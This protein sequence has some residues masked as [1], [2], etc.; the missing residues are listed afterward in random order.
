MRRWLPWLVA[1]LG[2]LPLLAVSGMYWALS[3]PGGDPVA[4]P[5]SAIALDSPEGA[6][7]LAEAEGRTDHQGLMA[8]FEPQQKGSWCGVASSVAVL[9]ARGADLD[10]PGFFTDATSEVRSWASITFG[11]MPLADL[12]GLLRAH[13]AAAEVHHAGDA[14]VEAFRTEVARNLETSGDWLIVNY[15]RRAVGES[16]GGHISPLTAYDADRDLVLLLDT[17]AYKYPPHWVAVAD[18]FAAMNTIDSESEQTRGWVV[19]R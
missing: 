12:G 17:A 1:G 4:L 16:G 2:L 7:L 9:R 10:Q 13:G 8:A 11:G 15:D 5:A 6:E 14:D 18:L 3:N 19:V